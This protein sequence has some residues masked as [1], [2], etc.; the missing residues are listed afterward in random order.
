[1]IERRIKELSFALEALSR[2]GNSYDVMTSC[3]AVHKLLKKT[4]DE[5]E[6][7]FVKPRGN[8]DGEISF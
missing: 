2:I 4:I 8:F 5:T 3:E 7:P 6:E 1:M